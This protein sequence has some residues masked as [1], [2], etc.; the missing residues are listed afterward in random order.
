MA[1]CFVELATPLEETERTLE[2]RVLK[3]IMHCIEKNCQKIT[4]AD[5]VKKEDKIVKITNTI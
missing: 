2:L 1:E 3:N 5:Q 4:C